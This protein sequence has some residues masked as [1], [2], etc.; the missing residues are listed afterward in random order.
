MVE[1]QVEAR[2]SWLHPAG[3]LA[4]RVQG[5]LGQAGIIAQK[6]PLRRLAGAA[7]VTQRIDGAL[8]GLLGHRILN[9][10]PAATSV[11]DRLV[12]K[13]LHGFLIPVPLARGHRQRS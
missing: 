5:H 11:S 9:D 12:S 1:L 3:S 2:V 4:Q 13:A 10:V 6:R 8:A 7:R